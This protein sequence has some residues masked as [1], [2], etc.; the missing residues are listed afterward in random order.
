MDNKLIYS[1][2]DHT[3]NWARPYMDLACDVELVD[4]DYGT[5]IRL[6]KAPSRKVHGV[7]AAPPCKHLASSGAGAW[8]E[9]GD[10]ALLEGLAVVD[11]CIRFIT[12]V[13]PVWWCLEN[14]VGRLKHYLGEPR[15]MFDPCDFGGWNGSDSGDAYTK[16]T[17]L[18]GRFN[19]PQL[20]RVEP[21]EGSKMH[22]EVR[23]AAKRSITPMGF[24]LAFCDANP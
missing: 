1:L 6:L 7:L 2:C 8:E 23:D 22:D 11:A 17:L 16:K 21:V 24:A 15:F 20:R 4:L 19:I 13:N 5:D 18:W 3:G 14:P 12:A 9:K 10:E